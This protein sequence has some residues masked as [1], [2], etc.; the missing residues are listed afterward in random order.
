MRT[1]RKHS[2][3]LLRVALL[4]G[5][6]L[7]AAPE[8]PGARERMVA[9]AAGYEEH[10]AAKAERRRRVRAEQ[11]HA[12]MPSTRYASTPDP[13]PPP[14]PSHVFDASA[15]RALG[16]SVA[17]VST[18][19]TA[20]LGHRVAFFPSAERWL[21]R[22]YQGFARV[23]NRT[24]ESGEVRIEAWG[25]RG[26]APWPGDAGHRRTPVGAVQLR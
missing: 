5:A 7:T 17:G 25:R 19:S 2:R 1:T 8:A 23:V 15:K 21:E 20:R 3:R 4:A 6:A 18:K 16:R 24:G 22:G 10:A 13:A 11:A 12:R 26:A 14:H 9:A